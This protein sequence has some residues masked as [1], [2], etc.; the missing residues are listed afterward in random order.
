MVDQEFPF[1]QVYNFTLDTAV[2]RRIQGGGAMGAQPPGPVK[3]IDF[4]G[5]QAP[6]VAELP[7]SF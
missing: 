1:L 3:S 2:Q 5:F 6:T 4:W 7:P